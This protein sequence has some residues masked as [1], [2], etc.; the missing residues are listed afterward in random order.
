MPVGALVPQPHGGALRN[1]GTNRGG[2]GRPPDK[3]RDSLR[4][5]ACN[6]ATVRR[7]KKILNGGKGVE[8]SDFLSAYRY[9]VDRAYGK[10]PLTHEGG[11]ERRPLVIRLVHETAAQ[12]G[13]LRP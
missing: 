11:D 6:G 1:G 4:A 10:A 5:L 12:V 13:R 7:L 9:V 8:D 3:F 2:S